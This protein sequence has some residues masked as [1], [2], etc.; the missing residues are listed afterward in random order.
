M[1]FFSRTVAFRSIAVKASERCFSRSFTTGSKFP[2]SKTTWKTTAVFGAVSIAGLAGFHY[3][4]KDRKTTDILQKIASVVSFP[5]V[6]SEE[7][8][9][10]RPCGRPCASKQKEETCLECQPNITSPM[11]LFT[12]FLWITLEPTADPCAVANAAVRIDDAIKGAEDPCGCNEEILAG[13]GF[14]PNFLAQSLG[15]SCKPFCYRHRK[16]KNG[17]MPSCD[18]DIFVHAKSDSLGRLFDFCK[19]YMHCFPE[20]SVLE[21][22]D[23]YG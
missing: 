14:G 19:H 21:F 13:V 10:K 1:A 8:K 20:D 18:G 15:P 5:V 6:K 11:K 2:G 23:I 22:E 16:G 7:A 3:Y 17:E 4:G 9:S 12:L